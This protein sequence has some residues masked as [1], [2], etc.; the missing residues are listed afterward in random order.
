[1]VNIFLLIVISGG[2]RNSFWGSKIYGGG[3]LSHPLRSATGYICGLTIFNPN[4]NISGVRIGIDLTRPITSR[5]V[6]PL[7]WVAP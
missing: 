1:M 2:S 3:P 7:V 6:M 5:P 4:Q